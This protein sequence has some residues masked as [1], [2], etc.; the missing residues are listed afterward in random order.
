MLALVGCGGGHGSGPRN[1]EISGIVTDINGDIVRN[2]RV[3][4][5]GFGET[6]SNSSGA[7][8]LT[9]ISTGDFVIRAQIDQD[10]ITYK[11]E[12]V[13]RTFDS[14][15]TKSLN[16]TVVRASQQMRIHGRVI[17]RD[18][19]VIGGARV[20]AISSAVDTASSTFDITASDGT[21]NIDSLLGDTNYTVVASARGFNNDTETVNVPAGGDQEF[22]FTLG[23]ATD[24]LLPAPTNL[25][26]VAWTSP[27]ELTRSP[28]SQTA[29]R[30]I[31]RIFEPR[32][33]KVK[34]TRSTVNGNWI[35][36]DLFWDIYPGNTAHIGFGVYRRQGT[37]GSFTAV[38]F[39]RDPLANIYE[40]NDDVLLEDQTWSYELTAINTNYPDTTNSESDPSNI[41]TVETLADLIVDPATQGPL[42][43]HWEGSSGA[44]TFVV[45]LFD[46]YPGLGVDAIWDNSG[47][48]TAGTSLAYSGSSLSSGHTYYYVVLG[49]ANSNNSRTISAVQSFVA[50]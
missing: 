29:I 19:H 43:F 38:D 25:E 37:S 6:H 23:N 34:T 1:T 36:T 3:W 39:L 42:T 26:G 15:R 18:G 27:S 20:F 5:N 9:D 32:T 28:Q 30:N 44:T 12:N 47:S 33:A 17:D 50:N 10:G 35:E 13:A 16:I 2:A 11:G 46:R 22:I 14:E 31:K 41:V 45:Y 48:P 4:I 8:V 7:Y 24:P 40:D 49:L 21:F